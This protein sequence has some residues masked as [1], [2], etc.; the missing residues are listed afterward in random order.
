LHFRQFL[1]LHLAAEIAVLRADEG[2]SASVLISAIWWGSCSDLI[3]HVMS[4]D[5]STDVIERTILNRDMREDGAA[6]MSL[7]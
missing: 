4:A 1:C 6:W 3:L 2:W 7:P 5:N